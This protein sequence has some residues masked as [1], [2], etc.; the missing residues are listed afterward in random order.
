MSLARRALVLALVPAAALAFV[1]GAQ[2]T[3]TH[4]MRLDG[5]YRT[6]TKVVAIDHDYSLYPGETS[7]H[8]WTFTPHCSTGGCVTTLRRPS[9]LPRSKRI[10]QHT[11]RPISANT[12]R[13]KSVLLAPC[14]VRYPNGQVSVLRHSFLDHTTVTVRVTRTGNGRVSAYTGTFFFR[15]VPQASARA[16][17]CTLT[18]RQWVDFHGVRRR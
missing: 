15:D 9:I 16:H 7:R 6:F 11:L 12:Y 4:A 3:G 18:E 5:R 13:A 14:Q 8:T 2:S 17:G 10:Y 1:S